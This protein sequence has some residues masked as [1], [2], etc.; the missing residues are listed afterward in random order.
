MVTSSHGQARNAGVWLVLTAALLWSTGG[1]AI[2]G[3]A[4][5]GP[6]VAATRCLIAGLVLVPLLRPGRVKFSGT[7]MALLLVYPLMSVSFV[8]ANKWTTAANAVAIQYTAPLWI[9]A[10][11]AGLGVV[12]VSLR[13]V[14]AMVP[15]AAGIALFLLEPAQGTSLK[16]NLIALVSGIGFAA[17][18][19][20]F[21]ALR[22]EHNYTLVSLANLATAAIIFPAII[23]TGQVRQLGGL[24]AGG[25]MTLVY[26][27]A[28]QLG[29]AYVCYS[30][31]LRRVT[32]LKASTISLIE[33][34]LNPLWVWLVL[35]EKPS[36]YGF[37]GAVAI[38]IGVVLDLFLNPEQRKEAT[39]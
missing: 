36:A 22:R 5:D 24:S 8:M 15:I 31:G 30:A 17:V 32:A 33:P 11:E 12:K 20:L 39:G 21:R 10:V 13:R 9:F 6:V 35:A 19:I 4:V 37:A 27:G 7:V 2:K 3:V 16:G 18:I 38:L 14:A 29:L 26:L 23:A 25:W 34:V 28:F 1:L